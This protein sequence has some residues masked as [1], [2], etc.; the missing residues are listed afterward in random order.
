MIKR[1]LVCAASV[2]AT[3]MFALPV[4]AMFEPVKFSNRGTNVP[5]T[6]V[7][8]KIEAM[9]C[10]WDGT[11]TVTIRLQG[12]VGDSYSFTRLGPRNNKDRTID[13]MRNWCTSEM[14][15]TAD[16]LLSEGWIESYNVGGVNVYGEERADGFTTSGFAS[17]RSLQ[18]T[19]P[20]PGG[21]VRPPS[22]DGP[23]GSGNEGPS[24]DNKENCTSILTWIPCGEEGVW[25][26]L[27][28][29]LNIMTFGV[30]ILATIGLVISGIQWMTAT[31]MED[32][33]VKA[34]SRIFN[35]V[36]GLI[37]WALMWLVLT[38]LIPGFTV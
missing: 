23:G 28:L 5:D 18:A 11:E 33:I 12:T 10:D 9:T 16:R 29:A 15:K 24:G 32:R 22:P 6:I 36:I 20:G 37:M 7:E 2:A 26:I 31:D 13:V 38:W 19:E 34:K 35:I 27:Q 1:F 25:Q 4:A 14:A 30:A 3:A 8:N 17:L 21:V